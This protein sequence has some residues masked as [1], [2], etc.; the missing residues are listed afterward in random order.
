MKRLSFDRFDTAFYSP[1]LVQCVTEEMCDVQF[2]IRLLDILRI[3]L[4]LFV[5]LAI[6]A[7][8]CE[9]HPCNWID[10]H[11]FIHALLAL[12]L[13]R[14]IDFIAHWVNSSLLEKTGSYMRVAIAEKR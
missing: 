10:I 1:L 14:S 12:L 4:S 9:K 6:K 3:S 8:K 13:D 2:Q 5:L 7:I 11:G